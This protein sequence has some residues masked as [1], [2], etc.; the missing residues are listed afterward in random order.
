MPPTID[1]DTLLIRDD[2]PITAD[3]DGEIVMISLERDNYYGLGE[4]GSRI[5]S[6]LETPQSPQQLCTALSQVY[7]VDPAT[8]QTDIQPFLEQLMQEKLIK[9]AA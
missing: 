4:T 8:C 7:Q 2:S 5:W 3:M 6:L 1:P 9:L